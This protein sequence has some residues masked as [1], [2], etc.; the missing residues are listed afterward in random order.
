MSRL[1]I[2]ISEPISSLL[3]QRAKRAGRDVESEAGE[4][5]RKAVLLSSIRDLCQDATT[6]FE[7]SG[8]DSE[9]FIQQFLRDD[10]ARRGVAYDDD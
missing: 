3:R 9:E 8:A 10:H 4:M 6:D 1:T 2:E 7:N 5:I